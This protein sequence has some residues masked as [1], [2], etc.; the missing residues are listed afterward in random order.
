[1]VDGRIIILGSFVSSHIYENVK[2]D[3]R[4]T[5]YDKRVIFIECYGEFYHEKLFIFPDLII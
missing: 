4:I 2:L 1:M 3:V 5:F